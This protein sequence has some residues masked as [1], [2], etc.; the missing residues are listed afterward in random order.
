MK[1]FPVFTT[2]YGAASLTLREIPYRGE[3]YIRIQASAEPENLLM[4]C[5]DFCRVCGAARIYAAGVDFLEQYPFHTAILSMARLR[6]GLADTDAALWPVLPENAEQW[7]TL[8]NRRM[9]DVPNAAFLTVSGT[10]DMLEAKDAY[11]VHRGEEILG[12]GRVSGEKLLAIASVIPGAGEETLLA[13][14]HAMTGERIELE[15]ASE[16]EKAVKLY[17]RMGFMTTGEISR[18]YKIL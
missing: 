9:A 5:V 11:F 1:D 4:E 6:E 15:V 12:I 10:K 2:Q 16:N 8:Y 3:A 13:L 14:N 18:W 7:R 17:S